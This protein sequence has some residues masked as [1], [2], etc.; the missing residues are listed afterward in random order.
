MGCIPVVLEKEARAEQARFAYGDTPGAALDR[1]LALFG[2]TERPDAVIAVAEGAVPAAAAIREHFGLTGITSEDARG[3]HDKC[4]MKSLMQRAGIPCAKGFTVTER[5]T[6]ESVADRLGLPLVLK[7]PISSGGRGVQ[8]VRSMADLAAAMRPGLLAEAFV[9][10]VEMSVECLLFDGRPI[11]RNHTRYLV[12]RWAN[13]LPADLPVTTARQV[14][15]L[16][17]RVNSA[18]NLHEG[19]THMEVFLTPEGPIF[20]EIAARPPGGGLMRLIDRKSV[21]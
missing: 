15:A 1:C 17:D 11:F 7:I 19:I 20:G 8:I 21:V 10:G 13:V 4:A 5:D 14:D 18:L 6:P 16:T 12:P 2:K 9:Y 3:V